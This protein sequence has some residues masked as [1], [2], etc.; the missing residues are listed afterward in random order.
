MKRKIGKIKGQVVT[1]PAA[2]LPFDDALPTSLLALQNPAEERRIP[3]ARGMRQEVSPYII[4][5]TRPNQVPLSTPVERLAESFI[6]EGEDE[7]LPMSLQ[8]DLTVASEDL[9]AQLREF[10]VQLDLPEFDEETLDEADVPEFLVL[11][12]DVSGEAPSIGALHALMHEAAAEAPM[13]TIAE[14]LVVEELVLD[15]GAPEEIAIAPVREGFAW[16]RLVVLPAGWPRAVAAFMSLSLLLVMPLHAMQAVNDTRG[17]AVDISATGQSAIEDFSRGAAAFADARYTLAEDEF[18]RAAAKFA[19]AEAELGAMHAAIAAVVNVIPQ[20]DRTYDSVKGLIAAGRELSTVAATM[21][22]AADTVAP[23]TAIDVVTKLELLATAATAAAPHAET[24]AESLAA[25]DLDVIPTEYADK[26]AQLK[27]YAPRLSA[28][29][30]EFLTFSNTLSTIMGG[31]GAMRYMVAFQNPTELRP[32][33]GFIGSFA[34]VTVHDGVIEEMTV[35]GGGTYDMQ[36]QL[37]EYV[38][39][40][41]PLGLIN[42]RWELQDANWF[43]DFP[44]SA[45]KVQWFYEH[46]GG[47]ST[48]GVVAVNAT[49][50]VKL[51]EI[52][53][54]V[55]MPEYGRTID[56]E[57]FMFETQKIVELEYD[58][59]ENAPKAFIGDLAPILLARSTEADMPTFLQILDL[60]GTSLAEKDIQLYF[61]NNTLEA[62][63]E[64]LGWS[65]AVKQTSGDYLMVVNTNLG[66]GKTDQVIDQD[67][68]VDVAIADD[69]SVVNTVTITK[70]HLGMANA[71]FSGR[72][73]VDYLRLYVPLGS[74]L[75]SASGF[76]IP[77]DELFEPS[78]VD[79]EVDRDLAAA[80]TNL[81]HDTQSGTAVWE[82]SGKTVFGNW[83]QTAPGETEVV[84]LTY[85][86]P[87]TLVAEEAGFLAKAR[88][89]LGWGSIVPYSLFLQKQSGADTRTTDVT[90]TVPEHW[91]TA[92]E[93]GE[94]TIANAADTALHM[95]F[96]RP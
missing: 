45:R 41:S 54:P 38:A 14:P 39:S 37:T 62:A 12:S 79:L 19:D 52:L 10:D 40:P 4:K 22:T 84:T 72:N 85:R 63:V 5:L 78:E 1:P 21:S 92:W 69:G 74:E 11:P 43:P 64:E 82:E 77:P 27:E 24:A 73:N 16:R 28:A 13:E 70:T 56:A 8:R 32:T 20:T 76:E 53:G 42:A 93:S 7:A 30:R 80:M 68:A 87:F 33:G 9:Q 29:L 58:K 23:A 44:T 96:E 71:L 3:I 25:V 81:A 35:P 49:F 34:E 17:E 95:L 66:G 91:S 86:L 47:P 31:D 46:A 67:V 2:F 83:M 48:D 88:A 26:V 60:V 55:E 90:V 61:D 15:D 57:N 50:V 51:L 59:E 18:S 89:G 75:L 36:G 65:G 6:V 94:M